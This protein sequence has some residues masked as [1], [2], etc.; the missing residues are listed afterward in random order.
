MNSTVVHISDQEG[1]V[2]DYQ[3]SRNI[4]KRERMRET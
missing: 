4:K 1:M 3:E 2:E